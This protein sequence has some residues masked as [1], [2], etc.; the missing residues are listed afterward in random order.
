MRGEE[1][2]EENPGS[3]QAA[4]DFHRLAAG[5]F[6]TTIVTH[7]GP[8][9]DVNQD[10]AVILRPFL[11]KQNLESHHQH[12]RATAATGNTYGSAREEEKEDWT[13][14][15]F[16]LVLL[17]GHGV[18]GHNLAQY[19]LHELPQL[20]A[21]KL[22]HKSCCQPDEWIQQQLIDV[23]V[24]VNAEAP[25][26]IARR[27]GCTASVTLRIGPKLFFANAGD[28]RTIL[29]AIPNATD[30]NSASIVYE[31]R[32]DKPHLDEERRRIE[33]MGGKIHIPPHNPALARVVVYS[34]AAGESIGLAMSRSLGDWEW[35]QVGVTAEPLVD[36]VDLSRYYFS[37]NSSFA[38]S[39]SLLVPPSPPMETFVLAASDGLWDLRKKEFFAKRFADSIIQRKSLLQTVVETIETIEPQMGYRDDITVI[40]APTTIQGEGHG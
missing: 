25:P 1:E 38:S 5:Q 8:S 31:T 9:H 30:S 2:E 3:V 14:E 17:D 26:S 13:R 20:L 7:R 21:N 36:V 27:G 22:N 6:R 18:E 33:G 10:R 23:F 24:Q 32:R 34:E 15:S 40:V 11:T 35:K 4:E 29:V 39:S 19:V 28:S 16:L 37:V 12:H